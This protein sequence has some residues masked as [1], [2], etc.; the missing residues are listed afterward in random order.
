MT[1]FRECIATGS[2]AMHID[3]D[4]AGAVR[5]W[6]PDLDLGRVSLHDAGPVAW[7]VRTVIRQGAMTLGHRVYFGRSTF[8]PRNARSL[9]LLV[10]ELQHVTQVERLG[11]IRFFA[12]YAWALARNRFRYSHDLP[13]EAEAHAVQAAAL[14]PLERLIEERSHDI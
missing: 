14:G 9:A 1:Y 12:K 7:F 11:L 4:V 13:L 10:H 5:P 8:D 3:A 6:H 2:H